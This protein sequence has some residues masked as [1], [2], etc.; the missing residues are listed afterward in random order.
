MYGI[1]KRWRSSKSVIVNIS[2]R[3]YARREF[4]LV[5]AA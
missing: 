4:R 2:S 3:N 1:N 5:Y